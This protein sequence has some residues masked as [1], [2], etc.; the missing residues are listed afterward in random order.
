MYRQIELKYK[1]KFRIFIDETASFG[2]LGRTGRGVTEHF[3]IDV[4]KQTRKQYGTV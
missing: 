1:Y 3:N 4:N 2:T